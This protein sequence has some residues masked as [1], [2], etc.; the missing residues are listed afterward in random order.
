M[1]RVCHHD[2]LQTA[3]GLPEIV[4]WLS[5]HF[6]ILCRGVTNIGM[7][8][9]FFLQEYLVGTSIQP[10]VPSPNVTANLLTV[11]KLDISQGVDHD[12]I[13]ERL[14]VVIRRFISF[15]KA[16]STAQGP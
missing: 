15:A 3:P 5:L 11:Q 4:K 7:I 14:Q 1:P 16:T 13:C 12:T 10:T 8:C 6:G 9:R 2:C